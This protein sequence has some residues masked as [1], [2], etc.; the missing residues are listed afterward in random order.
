VAAAQQRGE[1]GDRRQRGG[2]HKHHGQALVE[3]PG[4]LL[5]EELPAGQDPLDGRFEIGSMTKTMTG[6]VLASVVSDG[7]VALGTWPAT[8]R[9]A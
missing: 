9:R 5:R 8:C 6:T 3:R 2:N 1:G 7:M 4:E